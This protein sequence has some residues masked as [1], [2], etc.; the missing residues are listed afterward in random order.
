[1]VGNSYGRC[2]V[3]SLSLAAVSNY[4][5]K[6]MFTESCLQFYRPMDMNQLCK[7]LLI[8]I[9]I[10]IHSLRSSLTCLRPVAF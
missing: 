4:V 5:Y 3:F 1:M 7:Q 8:Y 9:A 6:N 10:R 2:I